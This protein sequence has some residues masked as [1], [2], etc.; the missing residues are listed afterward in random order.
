MDA[1]IKR[2]L[3]ECKIARECSELNN[4]IVDFNLIVN[5]ILDNR[6][7]VYLLLAFKHTDNVETKS[8]VLGVPGPAVTLIVV[9]LIAQGL[10][11]RNMFW[12]F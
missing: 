1:K 12:Y 10:D 2:W 6:F 8:S 7:T 3:R 11:V 9:Q 5:D 4:E